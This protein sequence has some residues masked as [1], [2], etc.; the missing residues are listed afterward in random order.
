MTPEIWAPIGTGVAVVAAVWRMLK[1][2]EGSISELRSDLTVI[3]R[4]VATLEE[5]TAWLAG[6]RQPKDGNETS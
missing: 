6:L 4:S 1:H 2:V 3:G 5:R